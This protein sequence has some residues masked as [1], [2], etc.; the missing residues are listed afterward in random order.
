MSRIGESLR[1][2]LRG[3][4]GEPKGI[5]V[6]VEPFMIDQFGMRARFYEASLI[7]DEDA[8]SSLDCRQAVGDYKGR[9]AFH[10]LF[11]RLLDQSFR[12]TVEG[13]RGFIQQ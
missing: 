2:V 13:G 8:I 12:L 10:E 7:E 6:L 11:Q 5:E 9:S 4:F 1:Q 3:D